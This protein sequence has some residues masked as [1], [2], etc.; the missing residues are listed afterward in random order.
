MSRTA[1]KT[2]DR[3]VPKDRPVASRLAALEGLRGLAAL[4][5]VVH[6]LLLTWSDPLRGAMRDL[7]YY[8]PVEFIF[9]GGKSVRLF[10]VL[11][12][13]VL[14]I[15]STKAKRESLSLFTLRRVVRLWPPFIAAALLAFAVLLVPPSASTAGLSP[16][17]QNVA[18]ASDA[19]F[20]VFLQHLFLFGTGAG[21]SPNVPTWS[22]VI[23]ARMM[24]L[25]PVLLW[26]LRRHDAATIVV[27]V[28]ASLMGDQ[29]LAA[30]GENRDHVSAETWIGAVALTLHYLPGF[31]FGMVLA[32]RQNEVAAILS[33]V[34]PTVTI[35]LWMLAYLFMRR[36][37]EVVTFTGCAMVL[38]LAANTTWSVRA[39]TT[40]AMQWLGKYSYPL[41]LIHLP[42]IILCV[43]LLHEVLPMPV[44][45][46][47][48]GAVSLT[49]AQMLDTVSAAPAHSVARALLQWKRWGAARGEAERMAAM[50]Q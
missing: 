12:G 45:L 6:H 36:S 33:R 44:V 28:L 27:V 7:F 15:W 37:F 35:V 2:Q 10:F 24:V 50:A 17:F 13:F 11:S 29:A 34:S 43:R 49:A 16:W 32:K 26:G 20:S 22:L 46:V 47:V 5:V 8:T 25:F 23:E 38:A 3:L 42:V 48:A 30:A 9:S 1:A 19:T 18:Q 41:Y 14:Y 4:A 21:I 40:P 39:L 31:A